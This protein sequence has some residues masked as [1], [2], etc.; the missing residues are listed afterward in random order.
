MS[1]Q[2]PIGKIDPRLL[3]KIVFNYLGSERKEV[4]IGPRVGVDAALLQINNTKIVFK[5]DPIVGASHRIGKLAIN[6]VSNDI[7]CM[8]AKPI[9]VTLV[10]LLPENSNTNTIE[11]I[12]KEADAAAKNIGIA[13]VGGHTEIAAGLKN[14]PPIVI[15]SAIGIPVSDSIISASNA[16]S[17]DYILMTKTAGLEGTAIIAETMQDKLSKILD[18][19]TIKQAQSMINNTSI[20]KEALALAERNL[21][22]AMHDPTDG[23]VLEGLYEMSKASGIGLIVYEDKIPIAPETKIISE[24]LKIDPIKLISSGVLL[25]AIRPE[26]LS[27]AI[28]ILNN[29]GVETAIIGQ[30][31][32]QN[33]PVTIIKK[34]GRAIHITEPVIDEL[35]KL[36]T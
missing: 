30:F 24:H 25:A 17:G 33:D 28:R 13:I 16:S 20:L 34:D 21:V 23:G 5:S 10:I 4:L 26:K 14:R 18:Q 22:N 15:A 1:H 8:G 32:K 11:Q 7:A 29:L 3:E 36:I 31:T 27:E 6:V 35:W 12:M 2:L 19:K 9:A